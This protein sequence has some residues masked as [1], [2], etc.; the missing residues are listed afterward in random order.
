MRAMPGGAIPQISSV[1]FAGVVFPPCGT[2]WLQA[3]TLRCRAASAV[4][5]E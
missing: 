4:R 1:L 5:A 3:T 2:A